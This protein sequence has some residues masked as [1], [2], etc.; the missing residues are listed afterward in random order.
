MKQVYFIAL[1][2]FTVLPAY[3]YDFKEGEKNWD[4][5]TACGIDEQC[6]P[7]HNVCGA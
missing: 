7:I 5:W 3:A 2:F 6:I 4:K 1:I